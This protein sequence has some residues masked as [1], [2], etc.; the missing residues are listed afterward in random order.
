MNYNVFCTLFN[1]GYLDKGLVLVDSLKRAAPDFKLYIFAMDPEAFRILEETTDE[2]VICV[3]VSSLENEELREIKRNR[4][5]AEYCWTW[6]PLTI[7]YV[8]DYFHEPVCTYIDA[9]MYFFSD[10]SDLLL[11][12]TEDRKEVLIV[13]HGFPERKRISL[14]K[15]Y[16]TFCVEFNTF[17]NTEAARE[18]LSSWVSDCM[19]SC[20]DNKGSETHG[21]QMYLEKWPS[22]YACVHILQNPGGGVA[23][24]NAERYSFDCRDQRYYLTDNESHERFPLCFYHF[25]NIRYLPFGLVNINLKKRNRFLKTRIYGKYLNEIHRKREYLEERYSIR[26]SAKR[27]T[28]RNPVFRF[29]QNYVMPFKI[30]RLSNIMKQTGSASK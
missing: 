28:Y 15:K 7:Q 16:G 21:D 13:R 5:F 26:F 2:N 14:E 27:S 25:Q 19:R 4:S 3:D 11:E 18:V 9:D 12:M 22:R 17:L 20:S 29:I 6:T 8:L 23:P 30:T 10:P 1:R 24:W